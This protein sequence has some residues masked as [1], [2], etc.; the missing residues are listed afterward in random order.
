MLLL[1]QTHDR[2]LAPLRQ[3]EHKV[4]STQGIADGGAQVRPIQLQTAVEALVPP[5]VRGG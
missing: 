3:L 1:P 5:E 2:G 4:S